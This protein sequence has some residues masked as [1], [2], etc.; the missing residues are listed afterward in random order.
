[1]SKQFN[2]CL[3]M[4]ILLLLSGIW[5]SQAFGQADHPAKVACPDCGHTNDWASNFC[6]KCGQPLV[7]AKHGSQSAILVVGMSRIFHLRDENVVSGTIREIH[8]D[9]VA[10]IETP[11]GALNIPVMEILA[12]MADIEKKDGA[13][14]VGPVLSEDM[15]SIS[16]K[17]PY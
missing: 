1:M 16:L 5:S 11:D 3:L 6:I 7:E 2:I 15:Q 14:F 8:G 12:E 17:T 9:T 4:V 13:R 10:V